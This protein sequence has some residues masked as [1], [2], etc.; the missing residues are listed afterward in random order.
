VAGTDEN[1]FAGID[2]V[3]IPIAKRFI[4]DVLE[5]SVEIT[6]KEIMRIF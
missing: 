3:L 5:A 4:V 2:E 1:T 6:K